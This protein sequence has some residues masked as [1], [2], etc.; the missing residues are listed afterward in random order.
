[1]KK[2]INIREYKGLYTHDQVIIVGGRN[3]TGSKYLK[4]ISPICVIQYYKI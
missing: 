3:Y 4:K 1:M 2:C